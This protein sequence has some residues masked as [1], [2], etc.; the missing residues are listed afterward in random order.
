MNKVAVKG[1]LFRRSRT[2]L[3]AIAV[4]IGVATVCG[5]YV[6]TDT[7][8]KA[9]DGIFSASYENTSAV[10]SGRSIVSE[11]TG[12]VTVPDSLVPQV[13]KLSSVNSAAGAIFDLNGSSDKAQLLNRSGKT[14]SAGG[15]PTFGFGFNPDETRFNP[16]NLTTGRW[17]VNDSQVV[18]DKG[19]AD[20]EGFEVGQ[21]I[22]VSALGPTRHFTISGIAQ[23]GS[24]PSLGGATIA[25][26]TVP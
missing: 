1:L 10:I 4:V 14:I 20:K 7:I 8:T 25:V 26:F 15:A 16:L 18:I 5:T 12:N 13:R 6:L 19:T 24:V 23:F 11:S 2:I 21:R 3:I 22:G 9:F 17:A